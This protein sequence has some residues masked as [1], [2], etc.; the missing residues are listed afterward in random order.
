MHGWTP[1]HYACSS[2]HSECARALRL[3]CANMEA[4]AKDGR[5]A[6]FLARWYNNDACMRALLEAGPPRADGT[7]PHDG[8]VCEWLFGW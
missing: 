4:V 5:S 7:L 6:Q 3:T 8:L 2:G 1:L